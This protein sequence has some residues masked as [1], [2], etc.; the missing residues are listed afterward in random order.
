M[1]FSTSFAITCSPKADIKCLYLPVTIIFGGIIDL[2]R[3]YQGLG[4]S[5][6]YNDINEN[7]IENYLDTKGQSDPDLIIRTANEK[8][9]SNFYF[10]GSWIFSKGLIYPKLSRVMAHRDYRCT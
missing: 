8:R 5:L 9:L 4:S 10:D 6:I 7:L 1:L 3:Y 2:D